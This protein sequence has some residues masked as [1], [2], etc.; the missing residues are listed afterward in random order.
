MPR[1]RDGYHH[2]VLEKEQLRTLSHQRQPGFVYLIQVRWGNSVYPCQ[3]LD[4]PS[5]LRLCSKKSRGST[6]QRLSVCIRLGSITEAR[7]SEPPRFVTRCK[8]L[9]VHGYAG[10]PVF[11]F[12]LQVCPLLKH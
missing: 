6:S 2:R 5:E 4:V 9:L 10:E 7:M 12:H 3:I 11:C 1:S 8:M